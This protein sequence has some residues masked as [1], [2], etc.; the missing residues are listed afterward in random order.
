MTNTDNDIQKLQFAYQHLSTDIEHSKKRQWSIPYY[1]LLLFAAIVGL[2]KLADYSVNSN[3]ISLLADYLPYITTIISFAGIYH[4]I[5][6]HFIQ[7]SNRRRIFKLS[8]QNHNLINSSLHPEK[9][10]IRI[11]YYFIE[12]TIFFI[13]I[14]IVSYLIVLIYLSVPLKHLKF[15]GA[16]CIVFASVVFIKKAYELREKLSYRSLIKLMEDSKKED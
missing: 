2:K 11:R 3:L 10:N 13:F 8:F 16:S 14:L 5:D 6:V 1:I 4:V 15:F 7:V 9:K 12:F